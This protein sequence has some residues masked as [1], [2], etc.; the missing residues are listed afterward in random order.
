MRRPISWWAFLA[1]VGF[2]LTMAAQNTRDQQREAPEVRSLRIIGVKSVDWHDLSKS[3]ATHATACRNLLLTPFCWFSRS[4][5]LQ[6][7]YY[8]DQTEFRRDVLRIRL[9]Y[10]LRGFRDAQVDTAVTSIGK[11][12]VRVEFKVTENRPTRVRTLSVIADSGLISDR[13]RKHITLLKEGAPLDLV[14]L[15]STRALFQ[16]ELWDRGYGD[17]VVD[18]T[19][20]VN[21]SAFLADV[22]VKLTPNRKTTIGKVTIS[23]NQKVDVQ[24]I[25]HSLTF[26]TGSLY[27]QS[28]IL[29]SQRNLYES[30]LFRLAIIDVPPQYDSVKNVTIDVTEAPMHEARVGPGLSTLDFLQFQ[31]HY[32]D[33]NFHGG[34]RRLNVEAAVGNLLS[35]QLAGRGLF[36]NVEADIPRGSDTSIFFKPTYTASIDFKQPAFLRLPRDEAAVGAF[37]HRSLNPGVFVDQGFGGQGTITHELVP[38]APL[39]INYRY[40]QNRVFASDVYFCMAYGVCD[41]ATIN[42][43]RS[44]LSLSPVTLT[45]FIDHADIPLSP[46]KGYVARIDLEHAS[47]ITASDYAYNRAFFDGAIYGHQSGTQNVLSAHVRIGWVH[48]LSTGIDSGVLHPRKRFYAGGANSVRG[49]AESLLGPKVLTLDSTVLFSAGRNVQSDGGGRCGP[50]IGEVIFCNPNTGNLT[51]QDFFIQPVGGTSLIEG[52]LEY[53]FPLPLGETLRHFVGAVFVDA[54][55]VGA[56]DIRGI[57]QIGNFLKGQRAVTPGFGVR[58]ESPVGPIRVD[59]GIGPNRTEQLSVVTA[60]ADS[61]G[62]RRIVPLLMPRA[63]STGSSLWNRLVL[64]FSIGEAY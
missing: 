11:H 28:D 44:R 5:T 6:D 53:R 33:Y 13:T 10:F 4:P 35:R 49:F 48:G 36:R 60:I 61:T 62:R 43:L 3:I 42:T 58:Y 21:D 40:E 38:R 7:R 45:G 15:D 2:P 54:G 17:G 9:Y 1:A 59:L 32:T 25:L 19:I 14:K 20:A 24:T 41:A 46:T 50:T 56:A 8:L 30:S 39:S 34:G 22:T 57:S 31:S 55:S 64:H 18:T 29:N 52:S 23:G 26:G 27:R 63:F 12:E 16:T 51:N 37:A 47:N